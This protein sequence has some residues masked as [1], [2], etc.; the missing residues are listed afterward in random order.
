MSSLRISEFGPHAHPIPISVSFLLFWSFV[1]FSIH[2][3]VRSMCI[4]CLS[5]SSVHYILY[6]VN[7]ALIFYFPLGCQNFI[8]GGCSFKGQVVGTVYSVCDRSVKNITISQSIVAV[9]I[10]IGLDLEQTARH[11]SCEHKSDDSWLTYLSKHRFSHRRHHC[12]RYSLA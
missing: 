12:G 6:L 11:L 7:A 9:L 1:Y 4:S 3:F 2:L 5:F 8:P 10:T